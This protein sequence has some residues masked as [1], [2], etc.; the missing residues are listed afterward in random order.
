MTA[1]S[2]S[3]HSEP[4]RCSEPCV[5][6]VTLRLDGPPKYPRL[7][8]RYICNRC[9]AKSSLRMTEEGARASFE[10]TKTNFYDRN[11]K[12]STNNE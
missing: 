4:V 12:D 11:Q 10:N 8:L 3:I 1:E 9:G 2:F 6:F 5:S 7:Y